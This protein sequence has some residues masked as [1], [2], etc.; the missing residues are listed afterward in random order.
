[1]GQLEYF[2]F[3]AEPIPT[4]KALQKVTNQIIV[5]NARVQAELVH[6]LG[7]Y[8][9]WRLPGLLDKYGE[10]KIIDPPI[11]MRRPGYSFGNPITNHQSDAFINT[12]LHWFVR[13]PL[14]SVKN[15][16]ECDAIVNELIEGLQDE[17]MVEDLQNVVSHLKKLQD[18]NENIDVAPF[19]FQ[20]TLT[21]ANLQSLRTTPGVPKPAVEALSYG[22]FQSPYHN[23][24]TDDGLSPAEMLM[25]RLRSVSTWGAERRRPFHANFACLVQGSGSGKSRLAKECS[26]HF[27]VVYLCLRTASSSE[28]PAR[29][30]M[31]TPFLNIALEEAATKKSHLDLIDRYFAAIFYVIATEVDWEAHRTD[32][33]VSPA[34]F[35]EYTTGGQA[36][37]FSQKVERAFREWRT[38]PA[39]QL[40]SVV[41][42]MDKAL[43]A[44]DQRTS[45]SGSTFLVVLD[46]ARELLCPCRRVPETPSLFW[47]WRSWLSTSSTWSKSFF[48]LLD[49]TLT[50][51]NVPPPEPI[52][53]PS[54]RIVPPGDWISALAGAPLSLSELSEG[55]AAPG[56]STTNASL[57]RVLASAVSFTGWTVAQEP[58]IGPMLQYAWC[59]RV[60]YLCND[61]EPAMDLVLPLVLCPSEARHAEQ[62]H[63]IVARA[64]PTP[65][66]ATVGKKRALE[67]DA[68]TEAPAVKRPFLT[69]SARATAAKEK[70]EALS[71]QVSSTGLARD[72]YRQEHMA[73]ALAERYAL[74]CQ[75]LCARLPSDFSVAAYAPSAVDDGGSERSTAVA[76]LSGK[77][78]TG[79]AKNTGTTKNADKETKAAA[80]GTAR[81][82]RAVASKINPSDQARAAPPPSSESSTSS[83]QRWTWTHRL[84]PVTSQ[85]VE[86]TLSVYRLE[87]SAG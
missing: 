6:C 64:T 78:Q 22:Y 16:A 46:E 52:E 27:Y 47:Q 1:M 84:I 11:Y 7:E 29:S 33:R 14:A 72:M 49:T 43:R 70:L 41:G 48:L 25:E 21:E 69:S 81:T 79:K 13:I 87:S 40:Y 45:N 35:W 44:L 24:M 86:R 54:A 66:D 82:A 4:I 34:T 85:K 58:I 57:S 36:D 9:H 51:T 77:S 80:A 71:A 8:F 65:A 59:H 50:G 28:I 12:Y 68:A 55:A 18:A 67:V 3:H 76:Q 56:S 74:V 73:D 39:M 2:D 63:A 32:G 60:G 38:R 10:P 26:A 19:L 37:S 17:S 23:L 20:A 30:A 31:A 83:D 53:D 61:E 62:S 15:T 5:T 42:L 75:Q